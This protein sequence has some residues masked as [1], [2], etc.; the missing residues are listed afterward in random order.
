[1]YVTNNMNTKFYGWENH[2]VFFETP[3]SYIFCSWI[4][5]IN[6]L[7]KCVFLRR[8]QPSGGTEDAIHDW[9]LTSKLPKIFKMKSWNSVIQNEKCR[10]WILELF[11]FDRVGW[12]WDVIILNYTL[13]MI[14]FYFCV[15]LFWNVNH[16]LLITLFHICYYDNDI[17]GGTFF[18]S[19][20]WTSD[21]NVRHVRG[22]YLYLQF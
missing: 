15:S 20:I 14:V 16:S 11:D 8:K 2:I 22:G 7:M 10:I 18:K 5:W 12:C 19:V 13:W 6:Y 17:P 3:C 4:C 1:M 9:H 21:A